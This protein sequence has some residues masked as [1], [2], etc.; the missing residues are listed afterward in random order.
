ME[1]IYDLLMPVLPAVAGNILQV[2]KETAAD[3]TSEV[4]EAEYTYKLI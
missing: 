1:H 2:V 4:L 3:S